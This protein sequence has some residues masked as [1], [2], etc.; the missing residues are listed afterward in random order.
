MR[1]NNSEPLL[2]DLEPELTIR[3]RRADQWL[4]AATVMSGNGGG[5]PNPEEEARIEAA[6]QE[7]LAR[8]LRERE[9]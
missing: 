9:Q 5:V 6:V 4:V 3:R 8:R 2:Y 7:R 1:R